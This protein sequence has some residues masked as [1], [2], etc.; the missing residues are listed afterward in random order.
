ME[1]NTL[2]PGLRARRTLAG[3]VYYYLKTDLQ[4]EVPL[5]QDRGKA[6][7]R[8]RA[9]TLERYVAAQQIASPVALLRCFLICEIPLREPHARPALRRQV[10]A[11]EAYFSLCGCN[12]L[13]GLPEPGLYLA[14]RGPNYL[15]RAG[16]EIRLFIHI[17]TWAKR[18]V[19]NLPACPWTSTIVGRLSQDARMTDLADAL[20]LHGRSAFLAG[21]KVPASQSQQE[22]AD[23]HAKYLDDGTL[24]SFARRV[25]DQLAR[26]GRPDLARALSRLDIVAIRT[27]LEA[28]E[29]EHSRSP[30]NLI[31]GTSRRKRLQELRQ[32]LRERSATQAIGNKR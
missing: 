20:R 24:T 8:W 10:A 32:E 25:A 5:G 14:H 15:I 2:P 18:H 26:D 1:K 21:Q 13:T 17:W 4:K 16:A 7:A 3:N 6:F 31:L 23:S 28:G 29:G 11:L 19:T 30:G 22:M 9:H 12:T 27:I